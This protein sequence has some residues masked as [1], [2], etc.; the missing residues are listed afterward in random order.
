M[1]DVEIPIATVVGIVKTIHEAVHEHFEIHTTV[2]PVVVHLFA[3]LVLRNLGRKDRKS[4]SGRH[5]GNS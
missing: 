4:L 5:N 2:A 1:G 3:T